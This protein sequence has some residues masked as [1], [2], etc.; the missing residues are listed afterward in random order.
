MTDPNVTLKLNELVKKGKEGIEAC[1]ETVN[2]L[3][4]VVNQN[5]ARLNHNSA[6]Q[7]LQSI[8]RSKFSR[9][10][11][12]FKDYVKSW[13][14]K[15]GD[16]AG[17][18]KRIEDLDQEFN[19]EVSWHSCDSIANK[20]DSNWQCGAG[21]ESRGWSDPWEFYAYEDYK[22][23]GGGP[24]YDRH[25]RCRRR[26]NNKNKIRNEYNA[27]KPKFSD[28]LRN[29]NKKPDMSECR[30]SNWQCVN[31]SDNSNKGTMRIGW[32]HT[33]GDGEWACNAWVDA[34]KPDKCKAI[35]IQDI[36]GKPGPVCKDGQANINWEN[37]TDSQNYP[38]DNQYPYDNQEPEF[39]HVDCCTNITA[40]AGT[41]QNIAQ[42]CQQ[43]MT[44]ALKEVESSGS[45][46]QGSS[47][48]GSST[49][50][51]NIAIIGGLALIIIL[52]ICSFSSVIGFMFLG[53]EEA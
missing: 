29:K 34:C 20:G 35:E 13:E 14:N 23:W 53:G 1:Q 27:A 33:A 42:T 52:C 5:T 15:E 37:D 17:W 45:S 19:A 7:K 18:K 36:E 26:D 25:V 11:S 16:F 50:N 3:T 22:D 51:T 47:T 28:W 21:A 46:T 30:K 40:V 9:L 8:D 48:Q 6:L 39:P 43:T 4:L 31:K 38:D 12:E 2:K 41:A 24:C 49:N 10:R 32:G 44:N